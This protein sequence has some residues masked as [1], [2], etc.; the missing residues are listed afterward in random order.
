MV[1][2]LVAAR[3]LNVHVPQTH[4]HL[5]LYPLTLCSDQ[6]NLSTKRADIYRQD[7]PSN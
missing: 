1:T 2:V 6:L 7:Y 5:D 4:I 3:T